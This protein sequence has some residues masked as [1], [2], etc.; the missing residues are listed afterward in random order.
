ML[1]NG[2]GATANGT[3]TITITDVVHAPKI[4]RQI[5]TSYGNNFISIRDADNDTVTV[6]VQT[7]TSDQLHICR[8]DDSGSSVCSNSSNVTFSN[9]QTPFTL[10]VAYIPS[11]LA[12][13]DVYVPYTLA[14]TDST[15]LITTVYGTAIGKALSVL[16]DL[17][18]GVVGLVTNVASG[19]T[20]IL[21]LNPNTPSG[22]T[23]QYC[24]FSGLPDSGSLVYN[25]LPATTSNW[26]WTG[27]STATFISFNGTSGLDN[28]FFQCTYTLLGNLYSGPLSHFQLELPVTTPTASSLSL[29]P[30]PDALSTFIPVQGLVSEG[31]L[32]LT[33]VQ[34]I[35]GTVQLV[36]GGLNFI[37][38]NAV[39]SLSYQL[40]SILDSSLCSSVIANTINTITSIPLLSSATQHFV[41]EI[42]GTVNSFN[43]NVPADVDGIILTDVAT[44]NIGT[45]TISGTPITALNVGNYFANTNFT[46]QVTSL[47]PITVGLLPIASFSFTLVSHGKQSQVGTVS[48]T[49]QQTQLMSLLPSVASV[50]TSLSSTLQTSLLVGS[51]LLPGFRV[52]IDVFGLETCGSLYDHLQASVDSYASETHTTVVPFNIAVSLN[53]PT[54][55]TM[56]VCDALGNCVVVSSSLFTQ[57]N[58]AFG[59]RVYFTVP[60]LSTVSD[61]L[62]AITW[63]LN[64]ADPLLRIANQTIS[65]TLSMANSALSD[66][67]RSNILANTSPAL[68][69]A[70]PGV[71]NLLTAGGLTPTACNG[72]PPSPLVCLNGELIANASVLVTQPW[73]LP[74]AFVTVMTGDFELL[75]DGSLTLSYTSAAPLTKLPY[76]NVTDGDVKIDGPV[77]VSASWSDLYYL[78]F[79]SKRD[80]NSSKPVMEGK[81]VNKTALSSAQLLTETNGCYSVSM[82]S[83]ASGDRAQLSMIFDFNTN[84]PSC[85]NAPSS[86]SSNSQ[87]NA[88]KQRTIIAIAVSCASVGVIVLAAAI[89]LVFRFNNTAKRIARPYSIRKFKGPAYRTQK[90][91]SST[92]SSE[93]DIVR[94]SPASAASAFVA[95]P[96]TNGGA[97]N[98]E[99]QASEGP[100]EPTSNDSTTSDS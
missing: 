22:G 89:F 86:P 40:C 73:V 18:G 5:P 47:L 77:Y 3:Y 43:L 68:S 13:T 90:S 69:L 57:Y 24:W 35:G 19:L 45:I 65:G 28:V 4:A 58:V 12:L 53:V 96:T 63:T 70:L 27:I 99:E 95:V 52:E 60:L 11:P 48:I 10:T 34:A 98:S 1:D 49:A 78:V 92:G 50:A 26:T 6:S 64:I 17:L 62:G 21:T 51:S 32:S 41:A 79:G 33:N 71:A 56:E 94:T 87:K 39:A 85:A 14:V 25:G 15:S 88:A 20:T 61:L 7:G 83:G 54:H 44:Q 74:V 84:N 59:S 76:V 23:T 42:N 91:S 72:I 37:A 100:Y 29:T 81:S 9:I 31:S 2:L 66:G 38:S 16:S 55:G 67:L 8:W 93:Y 46:Y 30:S 97:G 82:E 75:A 80:V 36:T